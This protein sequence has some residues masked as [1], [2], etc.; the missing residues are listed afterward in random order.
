MLH[1]KHF[2][3]L[4]LYANNFLSLRKG[5]KKTKCDKYSVSDN[6]NIQFCGD[7]NQN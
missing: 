1:A 2:V 7:L 5:K 6:S 4:L 3:P